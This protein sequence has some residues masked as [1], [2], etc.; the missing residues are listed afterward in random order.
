M[1]D[2]CVET[3]QI[4]VRMLHN[5]DV[6]EIPTEDGYVHPAIFPPASIST[7]H[8]ILIELEKILLCA[9]YGEPGWASDGMKVG[10]RSEAEPAPIG[11][12]MWGR[13]S[14]IAR[15]YLKPNFNKLDLL[16]VANSTA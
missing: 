15:E 5:F 1:T 9:R 12:F 4:Q 14:A 6:V 11:V 3:C 10:K 8:S 13:T 16:D 7:W 2:Q